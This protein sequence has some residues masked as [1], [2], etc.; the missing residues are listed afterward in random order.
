VEITAF[1][2]FALLFFI[3]AHFCLTIAGVLPLPLNEKNETAEMIQQERK[4]C[5]KLIP[6]EMAALASM[7]FAKR[8]LNRSSSPRP[9]PPRRGRMVRLP[10]ENS[11]G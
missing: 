7:A 5:R 1:L 2:L 9:S 8:N 11:L 10:L 4:F 3:V 6:G